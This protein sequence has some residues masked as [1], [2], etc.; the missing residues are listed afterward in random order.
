MIAPVPGCPPGV[1]AENSRSPPG[2]TLAEPSTDRTVAATSRVTPSRQPASAA[3][4]KIRRTKRKDWIRNDRVL[5]RAGPVGQRTPVISARGMRSEKRSSQP[6]DGIYR[7]PPAKRSLR[8]KLALPGRGF[9]PR[10]VAG[11]EVR[12][13]VHA[14]MRIG[15]RT[16]QANRHSIMEHAS[17]AGLFFRRTRIRIGRGVARRN[18]KWTRFLTGADRVKSQAGDGEENKKGAFRCNY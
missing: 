5:P 15:R 11:S 9:V 2:V 7:L 13:P 4:K 8:A 3:A 1:N 10:L 17:L 16:R 14:N 12:I 18:R 6:Q